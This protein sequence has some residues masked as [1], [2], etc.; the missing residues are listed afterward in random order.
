MAGSSED[1]YNLARTASEMADYPHGVPPA[2]GAFRPDDVAV[3]AP[4]ANTE[5]GSTATA[6]FIAPASHVYL[7]SSGLARDR[8]I[9]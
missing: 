4:S 3:S 9:S 6:S 5:P 8:S 1:D 7:P 2:T